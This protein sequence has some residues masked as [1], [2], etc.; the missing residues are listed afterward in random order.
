MARTGSKNQVSITGSIIYGH[1]GT[2]AYAIN[3]INRK[4]RTSSMSYL[5]DIV[6]GNVPNHTSF[7]IEG[8]NDDVDNTEEEVWSVGGMY[9]FPTAGM[10]MEIRS[11]SDQDSGAGG[12]NPAGT[13]VRTVDVHY[14]D[15]TWAE[16]IEAV[17]LDGT[18]AVTTTAV[19]ILR[20]NEMHTLT[21][22]SGLIAAGDIDIRH[23]TD[24][25]I[26]GRIPA[27]KNSLHQ[28]IFTVPLGKILFLVS[29]QP[30]IGHQTG[31][32]Y[33]RF[34]LEGTADSDDNYLAGIFFS[35]DIIDIEDMAIF[36]SLN[37][38]LKFPAKTDI[39]VAVI[40]DSASANA[41]TS[42]SFEGWMEDA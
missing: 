25:P 5:Q 26:Y 34:E 24:T 16:Q 6:E 23:L 21:T 10:Q 8:I 33:G 11:S 31:N 22:G 32:R 1:D 35:K 40:S 13:G 38:P 9:V 28:A 27:G 37:M 36:V 29:W 42:V 7:R 14:L 15:S 12:I 39:R 4:L 19:N 17:T 30:G 41:H 3:V 18:T 2:D 20:I